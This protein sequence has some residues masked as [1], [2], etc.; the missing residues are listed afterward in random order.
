M[1][2]L[3]KI[4]V[5][6]ILLVIIAFFYYLF[7]A[8]KGIIFFDEGYF[9]HAAERI[10]NG[11]TPY[12][13]FSL[14][15]GPTY[16][17]LLAVLFKLFGPSL[18]IGRYLTVF[19]CLSIISIGFLILNK[20]KFNSVSNI[21]LS[22]LAYLSFGYPLINIPNIM[23]TNVLFALLLM[24]GYVY[25]LKE[26]TDKQFF[27]AV[28]LG[29]FLAVSLSLKQNYGLAFI[30]LFNGLVFFGKKRNLATFKNTILM[31][32]TW[33]FLLFAGLYYFFL[34]DNLQGLFDFISFS[35][36]FIVYNAFTYPP[37]TNAFKPLGIFK[38]L[39]YYLPVILLLIT[40]VKIIKHNISKEVASFSLIAIAGFFVSV[41]PQSD[42]LHCYPFF[43]LVLIS[44]MLIFQ[45]NK[46]HYLVSLLVLVMIGTGFYLTFFKGSYY[47][48]YPYLEYRYPLNLPRA[49]GILVVKQDLEAINKSYTFINTHTNK[50]DYIFVYPTS[51]LLYFIFDRPNPSKD[52]LYFVRSW[53]FYDER[54][55][56]ADIKMKRVR[57]IVVNRGYKN[58]SLLS[59]FIQKQQKVIDA[60]QIII[61]AISAN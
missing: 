32:V 31:N 45:K 12:K 60:G 26:K 25:W 17:Y 15:Y 54:V 10:F 56:L 9:V 44:F 43:S 53:H 14:Q 11:L 24:L 7:F 28:V 47:Y 46:S 34:K 3:K 5:L 1:L 52:S 19:I 22:F 37:L 2:K 36:N 4:F 57:Y 39:P 8:N 29:F 18:I 49:K 58:D 51:P 50:G 40:F 21:L 55:I 59:Q 35:K 41:Y 33:T 38:L 20:L 42:L 13:D 30:V 16:F 6:E 48:E 23:W 27:Y 61:F